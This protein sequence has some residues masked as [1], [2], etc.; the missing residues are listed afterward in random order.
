MPQALCDCR[1]VPASLVCVWL[2][3]SA[4]DGMEQPMPADRE[5]RGSGLDS[6]RCPSP[7]SIAQAEEEG[8]SVLENPACSHVV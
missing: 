6:L 7:S 2:Q 1:Q 8:I 5:L 4:A 3:R